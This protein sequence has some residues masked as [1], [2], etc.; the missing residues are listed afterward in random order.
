MLS[1][2]PLRDS[3]RGY[4]PGRVCGPRAPARTGTG[5]K[6]RVRSL[7]MRTVETDPQIAGCPS[8]RKWD[9]KE[10]SQADRRRRKTDSRRSLRSGRPQGG[11]FPGAEVGEGHDPKGPDPRAARK[12]APCCTSGRTGG[13]PVPGPARAGR[14]RGLS[15]TRLSASSRTGPAGP[16]SRRPPSESSPG[17]PAPSKP[18][19]SSAMPSGLEKASRTAPTTSVRKRVR[20][21]VKS[22]TKTWP[23]RRAGRVDARWTP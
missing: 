22:T 18:R 14:G 15:R 20:T 5:R 2:I 12:G 7:A 3:C 10:R 8:R 4:R 13:G 21:W 1:E 6:N 9:A 19:H 17:S 23:N 16:G 11:R